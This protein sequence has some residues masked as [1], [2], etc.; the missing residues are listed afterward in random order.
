M[1]HPQ[2]A[3][4]PKTAFWGPASTKP[5][6]N[7]T[8]HMEYRANAFAISGGPL[9]TNNNIQAS[10]IDWNSLRTFRVYKAISL[11]FCLNAS[12]SSELAVFL[13][14]NVHNRSMRPRDLSMPT[15]P[16]ALTTNKMQMRGIVCCTKT[17]LTLATA[18]QVRTATG[19]HFWAALRNAFQSYYRPMGQP[20]WHATSTLITHFANLKGERPAPFGTSLQQS[21]AKRRAGGFFMSIQY[22]CENLHGSF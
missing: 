13:G 17:A 12:S 5:S 14:G 18:I 16:N 15:K 22:S 20:S 7:G 3:W 1:L 10:S 6:W 2:F 11:S 19:A 21:N 4:R 9:L 8:N